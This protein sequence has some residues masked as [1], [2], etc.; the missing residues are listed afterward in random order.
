MSRRIFKDGLYRTETK[1][2][3]FHDIVLMYI[4][5]F[6]GG[7]IGIFLLLIY[8]AGRSSNFGYRL[9]FLRKF[10]DND[11]AGI[12]ISLGII[13][14][15]G[16]VAGVLFLTFSRLSDPYNNKIANKS[17][18]TDESKYDHFFPKE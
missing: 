3:T 14:L 7:S 13:S 9:N 18:P 16:G 1:D 6:I 5:F 12:Y 10:C 11:A 4:L 17:R 8:A 15:I 2:A